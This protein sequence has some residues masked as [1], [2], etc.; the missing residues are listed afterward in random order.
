[1]NDLIV[2]FA[3]LWGQEI[4]SAVFTKEI[5]TSEILKAYDSEE[6]T[7]ILSRW[8]EEYEAGDCDDTVCF[9]YEK[10]ASL[11]NTEKETENE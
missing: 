4:G 10:L 1:M 11:L 5:E 3:I 7:N 2:Q 8:A 9:F 6:V